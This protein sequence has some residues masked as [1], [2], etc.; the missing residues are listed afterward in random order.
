MSQIRGFLIKH[1]ETQKTYRKTNGFSYRQS[2]GLT[3]SCYLCQYRFGLGY[4]DLKFAILNN[5][6]A[7]F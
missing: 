4:L 6:V 2:I 3:V 5:G 1:Y 7:I